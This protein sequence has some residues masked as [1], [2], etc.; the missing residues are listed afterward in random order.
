MKK[1]NFVVLG[2][3]SAALSPLPGTNFP[4]FPTKVA[5]TTAEKD[6]GNILQAYNQVNSNDVG[7]Y[8]A[9][10]NGLYVFPTQ[11]FVKA[12]SNAN[13]VCSVAA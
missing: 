7:L 10:R 8:R 12:G 11:N 3:A 5:P 13:D 2:A 9:F 1:I 4:E 6:N